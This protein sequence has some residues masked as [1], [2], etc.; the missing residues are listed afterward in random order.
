[1]LKAVIIDGNAISRD[2]LNTVLTNGGHHVVGNANTSSAGIARMIKLK[3]QI[4]CID[5]GHADGEGMDML[6][7]IR[8]TL[9]K[10]MI[11]MVSGKIDSATVQNALQRGVHGFIVK[12][13]NSSTVLTTIRNT[14]MKFARQQQ[15]KADG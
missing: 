5:I 1:M 3:P 4:V 14:V 9:P 12:P 10:T 8:S 7:M 13:F 2:L 6:D 15:T 11:F